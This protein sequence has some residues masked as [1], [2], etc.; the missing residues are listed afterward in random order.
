M[1]FLLIVMVFLAVHFFFIHKINIISAFA[2]LGIY[3]VY[4]I[5]VVV[6]SS[7]SKKEIESDMHSMSIN[8][9][10]KDFLNFAGDHKKKHAE[11]HI[12]QIENDYEEELSKKIKPGQL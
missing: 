3:S 12:S 9:T 2:F 11:S 5:M 4:V 7:Q 6:Q 10:A 8:A 1:I